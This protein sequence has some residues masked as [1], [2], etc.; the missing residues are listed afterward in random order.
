MTLHQVVVVLGV[1]LAFALLAVLAALWPAR[2]GRVVLSM[3][4]RPAG[5]GAVVHALTTARRGFHLRSR[6]AGA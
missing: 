1:L 3:T 4:R 2:R 5:S 6:R